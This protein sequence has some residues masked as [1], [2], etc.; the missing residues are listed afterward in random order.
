MH[1]HMEVY[2]KIVDTLSNIRDD[3]KA[4]VLL[5]ELIENGRLKWT[6]KKVRTLGIFRRG[7]RK[8]IDQVEIEKDPKFGTFR[9]LL[10]SIWREG[11]YDSLPKGIFH[12]LRKEN[13][14]KDIGQVKKDVEAEQQERQA[15]RDF[16]FPIEQEF[17]N[18]RIALEMAER[19]VLAGFKSDT[20]ARYFAEQFWGLDVEGIANEQ[21]ISLLYLLPYAFSY[22]GR[23]E[24]LSTL[25]SIV[26]DDPARW[27]WAYGNRREAKESEVLPLGNSFLGENLVLGETF[28]DDIPGLIMIVGPMSPR[29]A[30]SYLPG[31]GQYKLVRILERFFLPIEARLDIQLEIEPEGRR[32]VPGNGQEKREPVYN[33]IL[34]YTTFI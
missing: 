7:Y 5:T 9:H 14:K 27:R 3:I 2:R 15:A 8:D 25:F 33:N 11:L 10:F 29:R 6:E 13:Q 4:E 34:G 21:V 24:E 20:G 18:Q 17:Y 30:A 19:K 23:L 28:E 31:R 22:K 32:F 1:S 26:L 12:D 16:F